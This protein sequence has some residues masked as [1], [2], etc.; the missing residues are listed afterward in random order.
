MK[1]P[2]ITLHQPWAQFVAEGWKTIETRTHNK[3]KCL[4]G[5]TIMIHA[6]AKFNYNFAYEYLTIDQLNIV[7][8]MRPLEPQILCTAY[9]NNY[10]ILTSANSKDALIDCEHTQRYGLFLTDIK[11]IDP[12]FIKG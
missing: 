6:G 12:I 11:K 1:I 3:F 5:K 4:L 7:K 8:E 2:V 10:N 9:V